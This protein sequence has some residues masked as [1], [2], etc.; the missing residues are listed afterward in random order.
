[1]TANQTPPAAKTIRPKF[2][3][4]NWK[5]NGRIDHALQF[6]EFLTEDWV[7]QNLMRRQRYAIICPPASLLYP[8]A[9]EMRRL[10]GRE[11]PFMLGGQ[12]C[13]AEA[14][15]GAFTGE[16]AAVMLRDAG[17]HFTLVG[18]SERRARHSESSDIV[19]AK[20]V[21]A[22]EGGLIPIICIGETQTEREAGQTN[23][24]VGGQLRQ[25]L[26]E[27]LPILNQPSDQSREDATQYL[28]A[29]I[30]YEP[31]W[32]IGTG[33]VPTPAEIAAIHGVIREI[34]AELC[35]GQAAIMPILYGGSVKPD[36]ADAILAIENVDGL[37]VGGASLTSDS[38]RALCAAGA[39]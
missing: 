29:M 3:I 26:A 22:I 31:V 2:I 6:L 8:M 17:A 16:I 34:L 19:A 10:I 11:R 37:L 39:A 9:D 38:F 21:R 32:A 33:L 36:N 24:V 15:M 12:D 5:M 20:A 14:K 35:P 4:G 30:A 28:Q 1:M 25:S 27:I 18:H 7:R 13:S 23:D